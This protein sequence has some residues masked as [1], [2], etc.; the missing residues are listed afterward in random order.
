MVYFELKTISAIIYDASHSSQI[1]VNRFRRTARIL[2][3][4][5]P[6]RDL[7]CELHEISG[8]LLLPEL[9]SQATGSVET[10]AIAGLSMVAVTNATSALSALL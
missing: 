10:L 1:N 8:T 4:S 7:K 3:K 5:C 6:I 9:R 2:R